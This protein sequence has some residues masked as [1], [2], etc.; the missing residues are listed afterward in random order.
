MN[1][2]SSMNVMVM[3]FHCRVL[4]EICFEDCFVFCNRGIGLYR[5]LSCDDVLGGPFVH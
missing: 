2:M 1:M 3:D 5:V 4:L